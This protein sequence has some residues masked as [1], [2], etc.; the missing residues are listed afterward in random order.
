M[1][2]ASNR[3][4]VCLVC[5]FAVVLLPSVVQAQG[6]DLGTIRGTV[7]DATGA[8]VP[9]ASVT[10]VDVN[11]NARR[12]FTTNTSGEYEATDLRSGTYKVNIAMKGFSVL[13]IA[14]VELRTSETG[15][16]EHTSEL[17]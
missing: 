13:E 7:T 9:K 14:G 17:Q 16:E 5:L 11:T 12:T 10:I 15:S 1:S 2:I 8:V 6:T 4:I 3:P